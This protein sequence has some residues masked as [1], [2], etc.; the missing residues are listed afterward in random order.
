MTAQA[1]ADRLAASGR[2]SL[3]HDPNTDDGENLW[4]GTSGAFSLTQMLDSWGEEKQY[5]TN[6][7]FPNV[8]PTHHWSD[9]GH[10]TQMIWSTTTQVGCG[11][12]TGSGFDFFVCRYSPPGNFR[13]QRVY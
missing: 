12:S 7:I 10:Y 9:V 3:Q 4:M 8:S 11:I 5:F 2:R 1:W 13:G 6:G